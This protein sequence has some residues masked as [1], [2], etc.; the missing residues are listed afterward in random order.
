[1]PIFVKD[2]WL[3]K[4]T[5]LE[6]VYSLFDLLYLDVFGVYPFFATV[7]SNQ[8]P[9]AHDFGPEFGD[10]SAPEAVTFKLCTHKNKEETAITTSNYCSENVRTWKRC[11]VHFLHRIACYKYG[12]LPKL[13]QQQTSTDHQLMDW[14]WGQMFKHFPYRWMHWLLE[15]TILREFENLLYI[16]NVSSVSN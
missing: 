4:L 7:I 16:T 2:P 13:P 6:H 5:L 14:S 8:R 9:T 11:S 1:M 3:Q 12:M 15:L 10:I